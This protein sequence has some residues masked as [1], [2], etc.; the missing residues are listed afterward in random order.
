MG[1][2][3]RAPEPTEL[4]KLKGSHRAKSRE[5]QGEPTLPIK[6]PL[7]PSWL[8]K[9]GKA[10]WRRQAKH[11]LAMRCVTEADRAALTCW[12]EAWAEFVA[13]VAAIQLKVKPV[14][15]GGLG[16]LGYT[17]AIA[18]GLINAKTS[19]TKRLL[20]LAA[21][22]GFTPSARA[23]LRAEP[24]P[25]SDPMEAFLNNQNQAG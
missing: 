24:V 14:S 19:A 8:P 23:R 16:A 18:E 15:E 9:E 25:T 4:L 13:L 10:E 11:L 21:Q 22:F 7:C 12:C 5:K 6:V 1:A 2:R 3:G 17:A 20:A